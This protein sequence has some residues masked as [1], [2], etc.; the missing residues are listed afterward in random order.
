MIPVSAMAWKRWY[1]ALW[2]VWGMCLSSS[3][4]ILSGP[5]ALWLGRRRRASLNMS[6][7]ILRILICVLGVGCLELCCAMGKLHVGLCYDLV[8][9]T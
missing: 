6:G 2:N 5:G 7:V 1:R 3:P 8:A 4:G 9:A